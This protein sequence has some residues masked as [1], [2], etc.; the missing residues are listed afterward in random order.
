MKSYALLVIVFALV[1]SVAETQDCSADPLSGSFEFSELCR[2]LR[3]RDGVRFGEVC[4]DTKLNNK[5][6]DP[7]VLFSPSC[8]RAKF[9]ADD[10]YEWNLLRAGAHFGEPP[11]GRDRYTSYRNIDRW[12][13]ENEVVDTIGVARVLICP[14]ELQGQTSCCGQSVGLVV[15]AVISATGDGE[16]QIRVFLSAEDEDDVCTTRDDDNTTSCEVMIACPPCE[17]GQ[18]RG[19]GGVCEDV[20]MF[21]C[22]ID[23]VPFIGDDDSCDCRTPTPGPVALEC[24]TVNSLQFE[25]GSGSR[26][27]LLQGFSLGSPLE[28]FA[29]CRFVMDNF[30]VGGGPCEQPI[31]VGDLKSYFQCDVGVPFVN[32]CGECT[33]VNFFSPGCAIGDDETFTLIS[34]AVIWYCRMEGAG[35][36]PII[37]ATCASEF[38]DGRNYCDLSDGACNCPATIPAPATFP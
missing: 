37:L 10:G 25:T 13:I 23:E 38:P 30:A 22:P 9:R 21:K 18:C 32:G 6:D 4:V 36:N 17:D 35:S 26:Y 31:V 8:I 14:E 20:E 24:G 29:A 11:T 2:P 27:F 28:Q 3:D 15:S 16:G 12:K 34:T 19:P 7:L 5:I 33:G 1:H